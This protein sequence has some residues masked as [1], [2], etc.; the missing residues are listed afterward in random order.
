MGVPLGPR[1]SGVGIITNP[2]SRSNKR[3]PL[4]MRRLGYLV[5]TRGAA[6]ATRSLDDL[7]RAAEEFKG[8]GIDV[9]GINGGDG[10]LHVTLTAFLQVYGA[11]PLPAIAI[12]RGGTLN[13][14]AKG[15]GIR[16]RPDDLLFSV[17]DHYHNREPIPYIE[18]PLL[19]VQSDGE[20]QYGFIFGN[21]LIAHFL[22]AYYATG[23]PSP[24]TGGKL[25]VRTV[26]SALFGTPLVKAL[27]R[28]FVGQVRVDG[29]A[30]ARTDFT[31]VT[32]ATVPE[33]GLGFKPYHRYAEKPDHFALLGIHAGPTAVAAELPRVWMGKPMRRD[34]AIS[35][36]ARH[37]E[38]G[39]DQPFGY[40]IDG[41]SYPA[42]PG[43]T[44]V[45]VSTGPT[46]RLLIPP[47]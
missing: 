42:R 47:A 8:A 20:P 26:L 7:Y 32:A 16:G 37:V 19:R 1:V 45:T 24:L 14:I 6:A 35:A 25:L 44:Q 3:D 46:L 4:G 23:K 11:V 34:K 12:L 2:R 18:R 28:R 41:D 15:L 36:V 13:T 5:G 17:L 33:I 38:I 39:S 31:T 27:F 40:I 29:E 9:L 22:E 30:W 21:G 43:Q 10:T